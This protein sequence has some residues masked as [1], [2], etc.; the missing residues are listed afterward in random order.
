[1]AI[2]ACT[3]HLDTTTA[4]FGN[5]HHTTLN[6]YEDLTLRGPSCCIQSILRASHAQLASVLYN[7]AVQFHP[8]LNPNRSWRDA[9]AASKR[10]MTVVNACHIKT[11][12]IARHSSCSSTGLLFDCTQTKHALA[13]MQHC[14]SMP[15]PLLP[16]LPVHQACW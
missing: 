12:A 15:P 9:P 1:M 11:A 7:A 5:S 10:S 2:R 4:I 8:Q 14:H 16:V 6:Q 3:E 13:E